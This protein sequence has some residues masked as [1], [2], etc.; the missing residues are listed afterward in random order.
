MTTTE[1]VNKFYQLN[2]DIRLGKAEMKDLRAILT[3]DFVF[4]GPLMK[5][6]GAD[7]YIG[8]LTQFIPFHEALKI[9]EQFFD[10][11]KACNITEL[12]V[13]SP[14][15]KIITM[16]IAEYLVAENGKLK[17]HTLYYDPRAFAE[18]FPM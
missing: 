13:K 8:L 1:V 4:T 2:I 16:D 6:E 18:A 14:S 17:T 10:N 12:K 11:N 5:I 3:D 15:G 9:I 7:N